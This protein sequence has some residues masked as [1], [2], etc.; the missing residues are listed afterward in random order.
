MQLSAPRLAAAALAL[1]P[2]STLGLA[3]VLGEPRPDSA[4]S[5]VV[6]AIAAAPAPDTP[7][8]V[9]VGAYINDIQELDF[10]TNSYV[11]DLCLVPLE[12]ARPRSLQDHGVHEPLRP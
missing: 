5:A 8:K 3:P 1:L 10:K 12:S 7:A 6:Q 9:M 11:V 2:L 4:P